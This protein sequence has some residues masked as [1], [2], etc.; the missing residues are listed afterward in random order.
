MS[1]TPNPNQSPEGK[2]GAKNKIDEILRKIESLKEI[3]FKYDEIPLQQW[4]V[5]VS[6]GRIIVHA[7]LYTGLENRSNLS[8]ECV[9]V[10][11]FRGFSDEEIFVHGLRE[12]IEGTIN[13]IN[14]DW[15]VNGFAVIDVDHGRYKVRVR[16]MG[17]RLESPFPKDYAGLAVD[18]AIEMLPDL[19]PDEATEIVKRAIEASEDLYKLLKKPQ[20]KTQTKINPKPK[21]R[22]INV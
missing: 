4:L 20:T 15:Y 10:L 3:D 7:V 8:D 16:A 22:A 14:E 17:K 12:C 13:S 19:A 6:D 18:V 1:Q 9:S 2:I 11:R 5:N 21:L